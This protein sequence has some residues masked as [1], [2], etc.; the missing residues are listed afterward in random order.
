MTVSAMRIIQLVLC[1]SVSAEAAEKIHLQVPAI[2]EISQGMDALRVMDLVELT[3]RPGGDLDFLSLVVDLPAS[4]STGKLSHQEMHQALRTALKQR[5]PTD[6]ITFFVPGEVQLISKRGAFPRLRFQNELIGVLGEKCTDCRFQIE[7]VRGP[8]LVDPSQ[9]PE[10]DFSKVGLVSSFLVPIPSAKKYVSGS[11]TVLR[12]TA[13]TTRWIEAG[14]K[15]SAADVKMDW[16]SSLRDLPQVFSVADLI[17]RELAI[18]KSQFQAFRKSDFKK[19]NLV[20]Q[21]QTVKAL[22]ETNVFE[23]TQALVAEQS[24]EQG[25][26]VR[27]RSIDGKKTLL[28]RV[29]EAQTVRIE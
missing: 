5:P 16:I 18:S 28:G 4:A 13:V 7:G 23:V 15:I 19:Q 26:I 22:F 8:M 25:E 14:E 21:G 20:S 3:E 29:V 12:K 9:V 24:G 1:F 17:G 2:I 27:L 6:E 11:L 10:F